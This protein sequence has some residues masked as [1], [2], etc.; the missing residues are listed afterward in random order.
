MRTKLHPVAEIATPLMTTEEFA[1]LVKS[2]KAHGQR[3]RIT[4][5]EHEGEWL[6]LDGA[7]REI[8]CVMAGVE[9]QY[10]KIKVDDPRDYWMSMNIMRVHLNESQRAMGDALL[11][12]P[13]EDEEA[14]DHNQ[15]PPPIV[16]A[17]YVLAHAP[18]WVDAVI[19]GYVH[20]YR[21]Y[22][23]AVEIQAQFN[24]IRKL[25]EIEQGIPT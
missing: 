20:I 12:K 3:D 23:E 10:R 1:G 14:Y 6:I 13:D 15:L 2:I 24:S 5:V 17:R 19:D 11:T 4:L 18:A 25:T 21:A 16:A 8:A 7:C 22:D 9:P